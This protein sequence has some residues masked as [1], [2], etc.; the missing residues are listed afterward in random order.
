MRKLKMRH[1]VVL[2][3]VVTV[4]GIVAIALAA[5]R[6]VA[7][8]AAPE[9]CSRENIDYYFD[10]Q[11]GQINFGKMSEVK[12]IPVWASDSE[13]IVG[14][15]PQALADPT[16]D[17]GLAL[18]AYG[19]GDPNI[20]LPI[21]TPEGKLYGYSVANEGSVPLETAIGRGLVPRHVVEN[22]PSVRDFD[23]GFPIAGR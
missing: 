11:T 2:A 1:A 8:G 10:E 7:A 3:S 9:G 5:Q 22:P 23:E 14:C 16:R 19:R 20:P 13:T 4:A 6:S 21:F 15:I 17:E 12:W 18:L